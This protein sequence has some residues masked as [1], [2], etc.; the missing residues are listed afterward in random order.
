LATLGPLAAAELAW[1]DEV[2]P[3]A[4]D[5]DDPAEGA[6]VVAPEERAA[7]EGAVVEEGSV[8]EAGAADPVE[9][10]AVSVTAPPPASAT[11]PAAFS[12]FR[13]VWPCSTRRGRSWD[14]GESAGSGMRSSSRSGMTGDRA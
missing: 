1:D 9:L 13:L 6:V 11:R 2:D 7:L 5:S 14:S 10:Q 12:T 4:A 8:V 3:D